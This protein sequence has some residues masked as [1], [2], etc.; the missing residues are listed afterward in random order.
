MLLG[1]KAKLL[2]VTLLAERIVPSED[3]ALVVAEGLGEA[4]TS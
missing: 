3:E 1:E 2:I 4:V